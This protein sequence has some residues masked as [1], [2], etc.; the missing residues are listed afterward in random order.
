[1]G[2]D[3][4]VIRREVEETRARM[5]ETVDALGYKADVKSRTKEAVSDKVSTIT[6]KVGD[7]RDAVG[8]KFSSATDKV[9]DATPS[10]GDIKH[11]ARRT[12]GMAQE[13]PL[14]LAIGSLAIG[15][16]AG[17]VIPTTSVE[18]EHVAPVAGQIKEKAQ[19][20]GSEAID[21]GKQVA[22]EAAGA[23][24]EAASQAATQVQDAAQSHAQDLKSSAQDTAQ[25]TAQQ[26][27]S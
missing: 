20:L 9:S 16:L 1:V 11:A 25:E 19:E 12:G 3:P 2:Q 8:G 6:G 15:F 4:D 26:V 17:L 7:A 10:T 27:R 22:Q 18:E 13:N 14:G 23:A 5:T 21:H 24:K